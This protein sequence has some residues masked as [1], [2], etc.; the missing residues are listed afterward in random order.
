MRHVLAF[1]AA[2]ALSAGAF[3]QAGQDR[4]AHHAPAASAPAEVDAQT[5]AMRCACTEGGL[6]SP[7]G[8]ARPGRVLP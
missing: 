3:A 4:A 8:A 2:A 1:A 7:F 6:K 5:K